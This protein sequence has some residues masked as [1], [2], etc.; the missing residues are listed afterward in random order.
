MFA[1]F[2][3]NATKSAAKQQKK[4]KSAEKKSKSA[5]KE[6]KQPDYLKVSSRDLTCE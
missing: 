3:A 2:A 6:R 1:A 5:E 4:S